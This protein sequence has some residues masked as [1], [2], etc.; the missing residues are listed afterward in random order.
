MDESDFDEL[1]RKSAPAPLL[2]DTLSDHGEVG[3]RLDSP[4][5]R[6]CEQDPDADQR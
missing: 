4:E 5:V 1:L 2:S 3:W 6:E